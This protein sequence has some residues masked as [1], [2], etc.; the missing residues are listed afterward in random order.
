MYQ[1]IKLDG[2]LEEVADVTEG[3]YARKFCFFLG[4]GASITSG[5]PAATKLV[6][7]WDEKIRT[8]FPTEEYEQWKNEKEIDE[9]NKYS[10]YSDYYEKQFSSNSVDGYNFLEKKMKEASP[11]GGYACLAFLLTQTPHKVVV[12]TNFDRLTEDAVTLYAHEFSLVVGHVAMAHYIT[13]DVARPTV[14]KIHHDLLLDP[15]SKNADLQHLDERWQQALS[16]IFSKYHPIFIGFAGNDPDVMDYLI[17]NADK[18]QKGN[19]WKRPYWTVYGTENP[20][21]KVDD[22]LNK[23]GAFLIHNNGFDDMMARLALALNVKIP[24]EG[25]YQKEAEKQYNK[26]QDAFAK[27]QEGSKTS[28]GDGMKNSS[29]TSDN[30]PKDTSILP[31]KGNIPPQD[32]PETETASPPQSDQD[33]SDS[34]LYLRA[35]VLHNDKHYK[36]SLALLQELIQK[37]PNNARYHNS[38]GVTL[39]EMGQYEE[40]LAEKQKAIALEPD[41]ARYHDSCGVTLNKMGRYEEALAEKQKAIA[42]EPNNARY[43]DSLSTTY[44][45]QGKY[46]EA[47]AE[48]RKALEL[49]PDNAMYHDSLSTTYHAQGKYEEALAESQKALELEPDNAMYH[50]S[51][52]ITLHKMGRYE[53]ALAEKQKAIALEPDNATYHDSCGVT[54]NKMGRYEE[55]LAEKQKAIEL[56]PNNAIHHGS[57]G[58][59]LYTM[60]RYK[61]AVVAFKKAIKLNPKNAIYYSNLSQ[62]YK[63]MGLEKEAAQAEEKAKQLQ[64]NPSTG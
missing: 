3:P 58:M 13:S 5:I 27:V 29:T 39:H 34:T 52:G 44:H 1:V 25:D 10:H 21:G 57:C 47:L 38:C 41:N 61:E 62:T 4:A 12:T 54:L 18:F 17:D 23:S 46:E 64:G 11:S 49:E 63:K 24:T 16:E 30:T 14:V 43:H 26:L 53:E 45:T 56:E 55:A 6:D 48:S 9:N 51:C 36:E 28:P 19:E 35:V 50:N 7:L 59:I 40:A 8:R 42:L 22:F 60:E 20:K 37:N 15:K 31:R 33:T 32:L 2:F